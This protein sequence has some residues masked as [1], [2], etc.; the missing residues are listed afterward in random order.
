LAIG[1]ENGTV[2]LRDKDYEKETRNIVLNPEMQERIWCLSFSSNRNSNKE[3]NLYIGTWQKNF[4]IIELFNYTIIECR[5]LSY[6]PISIS[7]F[8]DDYFLLGS[9]NNDVNF[10]TK[11]GT[12][13][14]KIKEN[15]TDW[16][17][18]VKVIYF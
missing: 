4:Y 11:E 7:L 16:V 3:Y 10:Y 6:D 8:K 9:N 17:L 14:N 5:R 13:V 12:F 15:I 18:S 1:F 2:S